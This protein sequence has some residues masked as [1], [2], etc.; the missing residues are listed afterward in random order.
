MNAEAILVKI[1]EDARASAAQAL[2]DA[3][4]KAE[5]LKAAS[6]EKIE[7]MHKTMVSQAERDSEALGQRMLRM[8]ELDD[9]K[10]LL[11]KKRA[12]IDEAFDLA[13]RRLTDAP[14]AEKRAFFLRQIAECAAGGET[15]IVGAQ[16]ADWFDAAFPAEANEALQ[17]AGK[18]GKL[19]LAAGKREGCAGVVL[20]GGG[21]EIRC[22]FDA[23]LEEARAG[24]EQQVAT[25]LFGEL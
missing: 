23:L 22:T 19:T 25:T 17:K 3:Q 1:E 13:Y 14:A 8:A 24:L 16:A 21:A 7:G 5:E 15:L 11:G 12:L 2:A 4:K 10:A 9:R 20:S 6:R 18:P